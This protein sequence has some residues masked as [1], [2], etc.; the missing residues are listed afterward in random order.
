MRRK[1]TTDI[2]T[3]IC[4]HRFRRVLTLRITG[5]LDLVHRPAVSKLENA[6]FRKRD[7][8]PSSGGGGSD[9]YSV[10]S[11]RKKVEVSSKVPNNV[12]VPLLT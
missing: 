2:E 6:T 9:T 12:G 3:G 11:L 1:E 4:G 7:L 8:F 5:F 10:G